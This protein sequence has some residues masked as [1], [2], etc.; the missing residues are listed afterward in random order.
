LTREWILFFRNQYRQARAL[1][2]KTKDEF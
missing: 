1:A 2:E